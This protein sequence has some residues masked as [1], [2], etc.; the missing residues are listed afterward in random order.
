MKELI[1]S[2]RRLIGIGAM[3]LSS[4]ALGGCDAFDG[5]SE[6]GNGY[7]GIMG[8]ANG[9][10]YRIQRLLIGRDA[11]AH[12]YPETEIRQGQRPNGSTDPQT[13]E[14]LRLKTKNF[15]DYRLKVLG[16]VHNPQSY[17]LDELHNMPSRTQITRHD[18]VEGWSC[19]AKWT[20]TPLSI[21]LDQAKLK[22]TARYLV[23]HCY[24]NMEEGPSGPTYYYESCDLVDARHPQ[25]ILAYG[26]NNSALPI[27]NGAPIRVR[28]ERTL[29]YKQPKYVHTI[30][31]V[32]SL[33]RF[34]LGKGGYWEDQGY[35]W[36]GG[37]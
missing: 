18:C 22:P 20:G 26:L 13:A 5:L 35:D 16:L 30:E 11:L 36:Y 8:M 9:L 17:S 24:D 29:G 6:R 10:T 14:Y 12:E 15:T 3:G 2:R 31:A 7:R 21:V 33:S 19:I 23:F 25:T 34:G 1:V 37:I 28:V 32:D 27:V 4:V